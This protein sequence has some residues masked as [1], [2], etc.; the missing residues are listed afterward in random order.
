[1][2]IYQAMALAYDIMLG[3][4]CLLILVRGGRPE[5][6]GAMVNLTASILSSV[7]RLTGIASWA[8]GEFIIL[9]IDVAV[10]FCF[11]RLAI[12]TT[13]FWP[14][15]AFGFALADI[16]VSFAG[17]LFPRTTLLPYQTGL[18]IYAYMA[19]ISLAIGGA[20]IPEGGDGS[21]QSGGSM[22]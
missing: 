19:L 15:W 1:M 14:I 22:S 20:R 16:F 21:R 4:V 13:R 12:N 2:T 7:A 17:T 9:S 5:R 11:Y 10:V 6:I 18:G 3:A 8:P